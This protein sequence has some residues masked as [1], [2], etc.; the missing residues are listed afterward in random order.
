MDLKGFFPRKTL[1]LLGNIL[2]LRSKK[3]NSYRSSTD[4]EQLKSP[5]GQQVTYTRS[6]DGAIPVASYL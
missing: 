3:S 1:Q 6:Q 4:N 2:S 5:C